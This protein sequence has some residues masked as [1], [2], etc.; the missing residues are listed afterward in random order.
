MNLSIKNNKIYESYAYD[1]YK[2]EIRNN[3]W[4]KYIETLIAPYK[5]HTNTIKVVKNIKTLL[6]QEKC[7]AEHSIYFDKCIFATRRIVVAM[8][9]SK[10]WISLKRSLS[11]YTFH[12]H[13]TCTL[14][15]H[16]YNSV[17]SHTNT[18]R[19]RTYME[20]IRTQTRMCSHIGHS[21]SKCKGK[22]E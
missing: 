2:T 12:M 13:R 1:L 3:K 6:E 19:R 11:K 16:I 18:H 14:S 4:I 5:R 22:T 10:H 15:I 21:T 20:S 9:G 7:K 17:N 8:H